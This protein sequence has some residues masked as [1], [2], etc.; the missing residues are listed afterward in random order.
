MI[1]ISK[2][3]NIIYP[4]QEVLNPRMGKDY[5]YIILWML[6]N[7]NFC[8]WSD[9]AEIISTST[10]SEHLNKLRNK[11]LIRHPKYNY[12]E[13]TLE[14]KNKFRKVTNK[15]IKTQKKILIPPKAILRKRNYDHWILWMLYN[16]KSCRWSDFRKEPLA[17]NQSSLSKNLSYLI[18]KQFIK[19]ENRRYKITQKGKIEYLSIL[20]FYELD[21]QSILDAE[22]E[23][24]DAITADLFKFFDK[25]TI[26]D[27]DIRFR[28]LKYVLRM[29]YS[30]VENILKNKEDYYKIILYLAINHPNNYPKFIS[31]EEFSYKYNIKNNTLNYFLDKIIEDNLFLIKFFKIIDNACRIYYFQVGD[32]IEKDLCNIVEENI[33]KFTYLKKLKMTNKSRDLGLDIDKLAD[34]ILTE[35]STKTLVKELKE[36]LRNLLPEYIKY[37]AYKIG[38]KKYLYNKID[39]LESIA[40]QKFFDVFQS[41]TSPLLQR[42]TSSRN[43][44]F[45]VDLTI[46][47]NLDILY[48]SKIDL[49]K[50]PFFKK[51]FFPKDII[52]LNHLQHLLIRG[53]KFSAE[54]LLEK[55]RSKINK[56]QYLILKD[57][58]VTFFNDYKASLSITNQIISLDKRYRIG[59]LLKALTYFKMGR[60]SI[61]LNKIK[62]TLEDWDNVFISLLKAQ[63][64]IKMD[65]PEKAILIIGSLEP[66]NPNNL[67]LLRIKILF[68]I[69]YL[70]NEQ[71]ISIQALT[72][73]NQAL[74]VRPNSK[75]FLITKAMILCF[76]KKPN[77]AKNLLIRCNSLN[78]FKPNV[79]YEPTTFFIIIISY[80]MRGKF[81]QSLDLVKKVNIHYPDN[82]YSVLA[83][84]ITLLYSFMFNL[85]RDSQMSQ[86]LVGL[87]NKLSTID[88][89][90][91]NQSRYC[92]L[93]SYL[94][95]NDNQI[96]NSI[97]ILDGGINLDSYNMDLYY[98][99]IY[100]LIAHNKLEKALEIIDKLMLIKPHRKRELYYTKSF[101]YY[102]AGK[103]IEALKTVNQGLEYFLDDVGLINNKAI[104]LKDLKRKEEAIETAKE[105]IRLSP[106]NATSFDTYGEIL[107]AFGYYKQAIIQFK[108]S[109]RLD[110]QLLYS[111]SSNINLG[112]CYKKLGEYQ[113]SI[114]YFQRGKLLSNKLLPI[115]KE[116]F[117][118]DIDINIKELNKVSQ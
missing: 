39:K 3:E 78:F 112:K 27:D 52:I 14:G 92:I 67:Y 34:N 38:A 98:S 102:K 7:N 103:L 111:F 84:T 73:I 53:K 26:N 61:A 22:G 88:S 23:R 77:D 42:F 47:K 104:Y 4:P 95:L 36:S 87:L 46:L 100:T 70:K 94:Y 28:F 43:S 75:I 49:I 35:I 105:L 9:L 48:I 74:K 85:K 12:Y 76:L 6:S 57:L 83:E 2:A 32:K 41:N 89:N 24:I 63:I 40:I 101:L 29:D 66:N 45:R 21:R 31:C 97:Q 15:G 64:F 81:K 68:H 65:N 69:Y 96:I 109:L 115:D 60:Y 86:Q 79:L 99:K 30:K 56:L 19:N 1:K 33:M 17:V 113:K 107:M 8:S 20:K 54:Q 91:S 13:I 117:Q 108:K 44:L 25:F 80:L 90:K 110:P 71:S 18:E 59:Y 58:I 16:N 55:N 114:H 118:K 37:L 106:E 116:L 11:G 5:D 51:S 10:L 93:K 62:Y 82:I 72:L 50:I